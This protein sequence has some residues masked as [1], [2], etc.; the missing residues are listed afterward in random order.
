MTPLVAGIALTGKAPMYENVYMA[1]LK[2]KAAGETARKKEL[3]D[4][5]KEYQKALSVGSDKV[6]PSLRQR[7]EKAGVSFLADAEQVLRNNPVNGMNEVG[8]RFYKTR[9]G[10][11]NLIEQS[12]EVRKRTAPGY[13]NN[14]LVPPKLMAALNSNRDLEEAYD[15]PTTG[16][17]DEESAFGYQLNF[18]PENGAVGI[19]FNDIPR[20]DVVKD[21]FN[22][23]KNTVY[24]SNPELGDKFTLGRAKR[25][26]IE[27]VVTP[28]ASESVLSSLSGNRV[29][30]ANW[31]ALGY[32]VRTPDGRKRI[33]ND[34]LAPNVDSF[35]SGGG[36]NFYSGSGGSLAQSAEVSKGTKVG[37]S[38]ALG[39]KP[40]AQDD[41]R[42]KLQSVFDKTLFVKGPKG[43]EL[44]FVDKKTAR[45]YA[46]DNGN[47]E[48]DSATLN[49]GSETVSLT[50]PPNEA[51]AIGEGSSQTSFG[52]RIKS[53]NVD[54]KVSRLA[55]A[56]VSK[57]AQ[58]VTIGLF[59]IRKGDI[60][61]NDMLDNFAEAEKE[62]KLFIVAESAP[63][64]NFTG[65]EGVSGATI[66]VPATKDNLNAVIRGIPGQK[67]LIRKIEKIRD[68]TE[69]LEG[70]GPIGAAGKKTGAEAPQST[71]NLL[72][73]PTA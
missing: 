30:A 62:P 18:N 28:Q 60:I 5:E 9:E 39:W 69:T 21:Y 41:G 4:A 70:A 72:D 22:W 71:F 20:K 14:F 54:A 23:Q 43:G 50:I 10:L 65:R 1:G 55:T 7:H 68:K 35:T 17:K 25:Q 67:D 73:I 56:T 46:E 6:I 51:F 45:K 15:D 3:S 24:N 27:R 13:S 58:P 66:Y 2:Q 12:E 42:Y 38:A 34:F 57:K 64:L 40:V 53:S 59:T 63:A 49:V 61:P 26:E 47:K 36:I 31:D 29:F 33:Y 48:F 19:A 8:K 32:D 16:L 11:N 52:Q 44:S 37:A